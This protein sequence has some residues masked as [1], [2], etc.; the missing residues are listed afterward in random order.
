MLS[1]LFEAIRYGE[2]SPE[3]LIDLGALAF[4]TLCCLPVHESAHAWMA[5]KLGDPTGRLKGRITL[6][7]LAHLNLYGTLMMVLFGFGYATPVPVN[8]RNFKNRKLYF[9]LT[10]LAGPVSNIIL[11][12]IFVFVRYLLLLIPFFAGESMSQATQTVLVVSNAFFYSVGYINIAL[13]V[14][15]LIPI[16]PLD[17]S[18]LLTALLPD[19]IYYKIMQYERYSM[20]ALFAV[21]FILGRIGFSPV[22]L[23]AGGLYG[24]I[25][26]IFSLVFSLF[27]G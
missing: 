18:R 4:V 2:F 27:I 1:A 3:L 26:K 16:P 10:A 20:I 7:P 25:D 21:I 23:F 5:D 14:F 6:N 17:G 15:N 11:A 22:A 19:R 13:A 8:I 24:L 9:A 12:V